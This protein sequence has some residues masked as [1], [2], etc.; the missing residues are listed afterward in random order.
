MFFRIMWQV[1]KRWQFQ[2]LSVVVAH[3]WRKTKKIICGMEGENVVGLWP[4]VFFA[5]L[6]LQDITLLGHKENNKFL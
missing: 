2:R 6:I 5:R 3:G 4:P 1:F